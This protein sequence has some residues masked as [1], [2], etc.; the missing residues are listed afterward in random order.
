MPRPT[1]KPQLLEAASTSF[2]KLTSLWDTFTPEQ[3]RAVFPPELLTGRAEAHW[4]RDK[5]LRDVVV[6]LYEWHNLVITWVNANQAGTPTGFF[7][8]PYTWRNY[9]ALNQRFAD[10]HQATTYEDARQLLAASH[11]RVLVLIESF[12]NEELFTKRYFN[13]TG[14]TSLGSYFVSSTSS[15]YEWA[16][17]K[18]RAYAKTLT[19]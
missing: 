19:H 13:W 16:A 11:N 4:M 8:D 3:A 7:P 6:H 10:Q 5:C 12:N 15:H 2:T 1:T 14:T 9:G 17:K 18:T